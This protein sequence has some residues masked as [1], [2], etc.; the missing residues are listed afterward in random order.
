MINDF[1]HQLIG[2]QRTLDSCAL[3]RTILFRHSFEIFSLHYRTFDTMITSD[4]EK[5]AT[6]KSPIHSLLGMLL[7]VSL[8]LTTGHP[9]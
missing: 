6:N 9:T 5:V 8:S 4:H 2:T 7:V 1:D 3:S